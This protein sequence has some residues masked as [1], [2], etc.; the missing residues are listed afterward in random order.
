LRSILPVILAIGVAACTA[1]EDLGSNPD[2]GIG[3]DGGDSGGPS[4]TDGGDAS[5]PAE[6]GGADA[7][8][9]GDAGSWKPTQLA[10]L[11]LWLDDTAGVVMDPLKA[12]R[13]KRWL[14]QSGQNNNA[15]S[16]GGDGVTSTPALDPAAVG[17]KDAIAC[18]LQTYLTIPSVSSLAFGTGDFGI[19][20]VA[21][22]TALSSLFTKLTP[23][24]LSLTVTSESTLRLDAVG[25]GGGFALLPGVPTDKFTYFVA[26]GKE[27]RVQA[28]A[29]SAS[30]AT[31]TADISGDNAPVTLCQSSITK[32]VSLAEVIAV[33]GT[34]SDADLAKTLSYVKA[35]FGL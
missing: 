2:G 30:G 3:S 20:I 21:K 19:V 14:D 5:N 12:G 16:A 28:G 6:D 23:E 31:S 1:S 29:N 13:V 35:K 26:R 33:K 7:S 11:S 34:L 8:D 17:G 10:G 27:L 4:T 24:G 25:T 9:A 32:K 15:E 22:V 18:D